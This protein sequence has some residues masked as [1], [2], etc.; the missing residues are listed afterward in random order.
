MTDLPTVKQV[1]MD[2]DGLTDAEADEL[3]A[4]FREDFNELL[5]N[6]ADLNELEQ[7]IEDWFGLEPDYLMEFL[8]I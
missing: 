6:G 2:R 4:E 7:S 5:D 1:L 3:I 8:P